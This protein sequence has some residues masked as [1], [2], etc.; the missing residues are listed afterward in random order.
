MSEQIRVQSVEL[1][2]LRKNT[3]TEPVIGM[4]CPLCMK[5]FR[6]I[7]FL[8]KHI[9]NRHG[10]IARHWQALRS[11]FTSVH[12]ELTMTQTYG[13]DHINK[14]VNTLQKELKRER[15]QSKKEIQDI[16]ARKVSKVE[17][18]LE[19]LQSTLRDPLA[20]TV[21]VIQYVP[22]PVPLPDP[23]AAPKPEKPRKRKKSVKKE[24]PKA[25]TPEKKRPLTIG[26]SIEVEFNGSDQKEAPKPKPKPKPVPPPI[27]VSQ[28][29]PPKKERVSRK[30]HSKKEL[31]AV[32]EKIQP[33]VADDPPPSSK[34]H[35]KHRKKHVAAEA[36]PAPVVIPPEPKKPQPLPV[37]PVEIQI[38]DVSEDD[39]SAEPE[40]VQVPAPAIVRHPVKVTQHSY[41]GAREGPY[42]FLES[43]TSYAPSGAQTPVSTPTRNPSVARFQNVAVENPAPKP[44]AQAQPQLAAKSTNAMMFTEDEFMSEEPGNPVHVSVRRQST[45]LRRMSSFD[46]LSEQ[47][48]TPASP[49]SPNKARSIRFLP[50]DDSL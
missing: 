26:N 39:I 25:P 47:P 38:D 2:N 15:K 22:Q 12:E 30:R 50:S 34:H 18:K 7:D 46:S 3:S 48:S 44:Q 42:G 1:E 24:S 29:D 19:T 4:Q 43:D 9:F 28:P 41:A 31:P 33:V 36:Q 49:L 8:D 35:R 11:P 23:P 45:A 5:L 21:P 17:T 20:Q 10:E 13:E 14:L 27:I 16:I 32:E 6:S 37:K 40:I